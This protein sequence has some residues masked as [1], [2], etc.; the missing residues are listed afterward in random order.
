MH[1]CPS[2]VGAEP[3]RSHTPRNQRLE[4][5]TH[6]KMKKM[7]EWMDRQP[8]TKKR[9]LEKLREIGEGSVDQ[10]FCHNSRRWTVFMMFHQPETCTY[11]NAFKGC[12]GCGY[13][14]K[15]EPT[16]YFL[17][18]LQELRWGTGE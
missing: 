17:R 8:L 14:E 9:I 16:D 1:A 6:R 11:P 5:T 15:R 2:R 4:G 13:F 10:G 7:M 12:E 18:K 3:Q